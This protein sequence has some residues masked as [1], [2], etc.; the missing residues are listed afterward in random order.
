MNNSE[1]AEIDV[2]ADYDAHV[3]EME[4][5]DPAFRED[6]DRLRPQYEFRKALISARIAAGLTQ[7]EMA[8]RTGTTQPSI[9]RLERGERLP[10]GDTLYRMATALSVDF[11]ITTKEPLTVRPHRAA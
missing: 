4:A 3:A 6:C 10:T 1:I 2:E 11:P 7:R 5:N 9:A 8:E